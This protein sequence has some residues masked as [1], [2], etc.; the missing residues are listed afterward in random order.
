MTTSG[1]PTHVHSNNGGYHDPNSES[2]FS[3]VSWSDYGDEE[4]TGLSDSEGTSQDIGEA[5]TVSSVSIYIQEYEDIWANENEGAAV[6]ILEQEDDNDYHHGS[7]TQVDHGFGG[8]GGLEWIGDDDNENIFGTGW[9]D[10]MFGGDGN[11]EIRGL[12]GND[13]ITGGAGV[14]KIWADAGD[15]I[16]YTS[17]GNE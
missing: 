14:D 12:G 8:L 3:G 6:T 17:Y 15:D 4:Y 13:Y 5:S 1:T 11:D 9:M 10:E 7:S 2:T 16:I